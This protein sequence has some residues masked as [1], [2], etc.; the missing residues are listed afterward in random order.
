MRFKIFSTDKPKRFNFHTRYYNDKTL[1]RDG[2]AGVEKG[3]FQRYRNRYDTAPT[4]MMDDAKLRR[5]RL[6][7]SILV[8]AG[9]IFLILRMSNSVERLLVLLLQ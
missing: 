8:V 3:S 5:R 9:I 4:E 2:E 7:I 6:L 1:S